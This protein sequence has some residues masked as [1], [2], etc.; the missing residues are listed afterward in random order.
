M[1]GK[2][3]EVLRSGMGRPDGPKLAGDMSASP[4]FSGLAPNC[5]PACASCCL[6]HSTELETAM[7]SRRSPHSYARYSSTNVVVI[8]NEHSRTP[9]TDKAYHHG[10]Q[11]QL[12]DLKLRAVEVW[13]GRHGRQLQRPAAAQRLQR[14]RRQCRHAVWGRLLLQPG[15]AA[16]LPRCCT[17]RRSW[18]PVHRLQ[19]LR[20]WARYPSCIWNRPFQHGPAAEHDAARQELARLGCRQLLR[21]AALA[22]CGSAHRHNLL[23][24]AGL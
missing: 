10:R 1:A 19:L 18:H 5:R 11:H 2:A 21:T 22:G 14:W 12:A 4:S 9:S 7:F 17:C 6:S 8:S 13:P 3:A 24:G 20:L 23:P 15:H 16:L